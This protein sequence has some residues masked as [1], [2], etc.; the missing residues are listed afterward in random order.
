MSPVT[1][2]L[3]GWLAAN[4]ANLDRRYRALVTIAGVIPDVD[5][6]GIVAGVATRN[7]IHPMISRR[8]DRALVEVLRNRFPRLTSLS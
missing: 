4:A 8:A 3:V 6:L 1:H 7:S 2:F 5:G